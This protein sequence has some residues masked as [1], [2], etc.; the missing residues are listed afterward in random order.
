MKADT[1]STRVG[2]EI[3]EFVDASRFRVWI[4]EEERMNLLVTRLGER[5]CRDGVLEFGVKSGVLRGGKSAAELKRG[6]AAAG[7][8][9]DDA[10]EAQHLMNELSVEPSAILCE[11]HTPIAI[12]PQ[13]NVVICNDIIVQMN[14]VIISFEKNFLENDHRH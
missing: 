12:P 13:L 2:L 4:A 14:A 7:S 5:G 11:M 10:A 1:T 8:W 9:R 6:E 3:W